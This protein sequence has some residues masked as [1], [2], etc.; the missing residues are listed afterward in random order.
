MQL[1]IIY[2]FFIEQHNIKKI[3]NN[4]LKS[5]KDS[6]GTRCLTLSGNRCIVWEHFLNAFKFDQ[7]EF[8]LSLPEK[9]TMD[10]FELDPASKMR[11]H[12][13]EEVLDQNMLNLMKVKT[14]VKNTLNR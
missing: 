6:S 4:I 2:S 11:N 12:L 13:A 8:S 7:G 1:L 10:H 9:L 14:T 5:A 3:R